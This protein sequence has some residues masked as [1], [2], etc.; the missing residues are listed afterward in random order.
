MKEASYLASGFKIP[1][2]VDWYHS[3]STSLQA[4]YE[5]VSDSM[6]VTRSWKAAVTGKFPFDKEQNLRS[7]LKALTSQFSYC[8]KRDLLFRWIFLPTSL[9][10]F[11]LMGG[12]PEYSTG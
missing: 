10:W 9:G 5:P 6:R 3:A 11:S 7:G 12:R 4:E 2:F 1:T 8:L